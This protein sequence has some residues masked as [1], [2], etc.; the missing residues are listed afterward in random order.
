MGKLDILGLLSH[1]K[2][3]SDIEHEYQLLGYLPESRNI[4]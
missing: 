3:K 2:L 1:G 4:N